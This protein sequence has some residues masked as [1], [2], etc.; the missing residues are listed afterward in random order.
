MRSWLFV[1]VRDSN[2]SPLVV[3]GSSNSAPGAR[4]YRILTTDWHSPLPRSEIL[5]VLSLV[6]TMALVDI[7]DLH[8]IICF[9]AFTLDERPPVILPCGHTYVCAQCAKR[10]D[11]CMEC[12]KPLFIK[13]QACVN[14]NEPL[15]GSG[16]AANDMPSW[17]RPPPQR[18]MP[19]RQPRHI[20]GQKPAQPTEPIALPV[21]KNLV[22]IALMEV[23]EREKRARM[24]EKKRVN[25]KRANAE[26]TQYCRIQGPSAA[27][28]PGKAPPMDTVTIRSPSRD[29]SIRPEQR[30][31]M[32]SASSGKESKENRLSSK[33]GSSEDDN[34]TEGEADEDESEIKVG[35]KAM[36]SNCGTYVVRDYIGLV[37]HSKYP[38]KGSPEGRVP[39]KWPVAHVRSG[40]LRVMRGQ[41]V[42]VSHIDENGV[43]CLA[44]GHG[45]IPTTNSDQLVKGK[46]ASLS[47]ISLSLTL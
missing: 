35:I 4:L 6:S 13:P 3:P 34:S 44:R 15:Q 21:P 16:L 29:L 31:G 43:A 30:L 28:S 1:C 23:S 47:F 24:E 9:D 14:V 11:K 26:G 42:Q 7:V 12:R 33:I 27:G 19:G 5:P 20:Q 40:P 22:M 8:C 10:L 39:T 18:Q 17:Y 25:T 38:S 32:N 36:L 37:V 41:T 45:F 2:D 46:N